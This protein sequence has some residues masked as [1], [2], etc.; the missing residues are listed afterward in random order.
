[1]KGYFIF[2][3]SDI[4]NELNKLSP[5]EINLIPYGVILLN[6]DATILNFNNYEAAIIK[7]TAS[8]LIGKN[9]FEDVAP[10]FKVPDFYD[11][12]KLAAETGDVNIVFEYYLKNNIY[13]LKIKVHLLNDV[14]DKKKIWLLIKRL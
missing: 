6:S 8:E 1:M 13:D 2:G 12:F 9:F 5:A 3:Q 7:R 10:C 14:E 11:K 4:A